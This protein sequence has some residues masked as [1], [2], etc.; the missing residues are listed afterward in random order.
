M[1]GRGIAYQGGYIPEVKGRTVP[2]RYFHFFFSR[3][4]RLCLSGA[5]ILW[6]SIERVD[7]KV[8]SVSS[9][10]VKYS[11]MYTGRVFDL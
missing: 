7:I 8:F 1:I 11:A 3:T 9:K 6:F 2:K 10:A 4:S 5:I